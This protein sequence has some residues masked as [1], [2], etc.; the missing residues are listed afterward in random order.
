MLSSGLEIK[1]GERLNLLLFGRNKHLYIKK[2]LESLRLRPALDL[3]VNS[4]KYDLLGAINEQL[5][6]SIACSV[7]YIFWDADQVWRSCGYH[8][9]LTPLSFWGTDLLRSYN[10][11]RCLQRASFL[12]LMITQTLNPKSDLFFSKWWSVIANHLLNTF[13]CLP[14]LFSCLKSALEQASFK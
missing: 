4:V 2:R 11:L 7:C 14:T 10:I 8:H 9:L 6:D 1:Y 13:L 12:C 5:V 3:E